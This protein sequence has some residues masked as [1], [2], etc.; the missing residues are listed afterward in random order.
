MC[1]GVGAS[2]GPGGV[3]LLRRLRTP[4]ILVRLERDRNRI[5]SFDTRFDTIMY[6]AGSDVH[7]R[8]IETTNKR[9]ADEGG[10]AAPEASLAVGIGR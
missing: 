3:E 5:D 8:R 2:S 10:P 7:D 6:H 9:P 4:G 1:C